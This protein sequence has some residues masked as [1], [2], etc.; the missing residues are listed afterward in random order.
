MEEFEALVARQPPTVVM[1]AG[2]A[3]AARAAAVISISEARLVITFLISLRGRHT[4]QQ[5]MSGFSSDPVLWM[6]AGKS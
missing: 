6:N 4:N 2:S 1:R 5:S 3:T